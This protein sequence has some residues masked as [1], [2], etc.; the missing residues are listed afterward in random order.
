MDDGK[1]RIMV[2]IILYTLSSSIVLILWLQIMTWYIDEYWG[3]S[4]WMWVFFWCNC[5]VTYSETG[6]LYGTKCSAW[7]YM[8]RVQWQT[9]LHIYGWISMGHWLYFV[10]PEQ[11]SVIVSFS[12]ANIYICYSNILI[13]LIRYVKCISVQRLIFCFRFQ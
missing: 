9:I 6:R 8:Y 13:F 12:I 10:P 2:T 1:C 3:Q 7:L 4:H 5:L 11:W